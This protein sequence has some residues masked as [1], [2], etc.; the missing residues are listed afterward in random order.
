[1]T[2]VGQNSSGTH[3]HL[4]DEDCKIFDFLL[5]WDRKFLFF[6]GRK[7]KGTYL[8]GGFPD[9]IITPSGTYIW[10]GWRMY[11]LGDR[12]TDGL[13]EE[14][15]ELE[16]GDPE[17]NNRVPFPKSC[18]ICLHG[19]NCD[20]N[21]IDVEDMV[22]R[23]DNSYRFF[24]SKFRCESEASFSICHNASRGIDGDR[25]CLEDEGCTYSILKRSVDYK[26]ENKKAVDNFQRFQRLKE[27]F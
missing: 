9:I 2:C 22:C 27:L 3:G 7:D 23:T 12:D 5:W 11:W 16:D 18:V 14:Y 26:K 15:H 17:S 6:K 13:H 4:R 19:G 21:D 24:M 20:I 8:A 10:F 1:M 25:D